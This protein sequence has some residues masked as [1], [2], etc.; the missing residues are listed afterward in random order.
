MLVNFPLPCVSIRQMHQPCLQWFITIKEATN[1]QTEKEEDA[2]RR[3][4][5][6]VADHDKCATSLARPFQ[7]L[8][9][10]KKKRKKKNGERPK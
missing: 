8:E 4:N 3:W 6:M 2:K 1:K 5:G 7:Q 9:D 10:Q